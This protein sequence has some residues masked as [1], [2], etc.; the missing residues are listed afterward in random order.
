M[1]K[2]CKTSGSK[3]GKVLGATGHLK[4]QGCKQCCNR[5]L[6]TRSDTFK[7]S[8]KKKK[9]PVFNCD[10]LKN[11][12]IPPGLINRDLISWKNC[13]ELAVVHIVYSGV[14]HAV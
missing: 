10:H 9:A 4:P 2:S 8:Q 14:T 3:N 1:F 5:L 7:P 13:T 11:K 12:T 6:Q